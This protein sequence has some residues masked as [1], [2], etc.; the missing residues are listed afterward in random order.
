MVALKMITVFIAGMGRGRFAA[1]LLA[2]GTD[3]GTNCI[4]VYCTVGHDTAY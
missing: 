4:P 3:R 2:R 1:T